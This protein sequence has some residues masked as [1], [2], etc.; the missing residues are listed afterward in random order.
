MAI[1]KVNENES[2]EKALRRFKKICNKEGLMKKLKEMRYYEKPSTRKRRH[3][4]K[5]IRKMA[6]SR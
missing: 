3:Q 5:T 1:V 4:Q 2:F 6:Q